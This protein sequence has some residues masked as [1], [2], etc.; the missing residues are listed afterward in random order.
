MAGKFRI[1]PN[2][3]QEQALAIQFGHARFVYNDALAACKRHY[4]EAGK[5]LGQVATIKRIPNRKKD[6]EWLKQAGSQV[7]QQILIATRDSS[8]HRRFA[9]L[10]P[11]SSAVIL[12]QHGRHL[13]LG[14]PFAVFRQHLLV[15]ARRQLV[16]IRF[17]P[18]TD[19]EPT[20][21][22]GH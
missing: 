18:F 7:L 17:Q 21:V 5:I 19:I 1:Y 22:V 16:I 20:G 15:E 10:V 6:L 14:D 8:M 12:P 11:T 13:V 3:Q 4:A 9:I 2:R